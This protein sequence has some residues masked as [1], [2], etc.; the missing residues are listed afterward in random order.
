MADGWRRRPPL[1]R[2]RLYGSRHGSRRLGVVPEKIRG[3]RVEEGSEW[4]G[5]KGGRWL[6][7][8]TSRPYGSR[9][10]RGGAA[11]MHRGE[12]AYARVCCH[13]KKERGLNTKNLQGLFARLKLFHLSHSKRERGFNIHNSRGFSAKTPRR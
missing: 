8:K 13:F 11:C 5:E 3:G 7:K 1:T 9:C 10:A 12:H 2:W 4:E 6:E